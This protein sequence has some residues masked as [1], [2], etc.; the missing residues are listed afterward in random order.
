[1]TST[2]GA[3]WRSPRWSPAAASSR[4]PR[5]AARCCSPASTSIPTRRIHEAVILPYARIGRHVRLNKVVVDSE[6]IIPDGL[7][8]GE[9]PELDAKRFRRTEDGVTPDHRADDRSAQELTLRDGAAEGPLGRL[10]SL[11]ARQD[12]RPRRCRGRAA[13]RAEARGRRDAHASAS[14]SAGQG[15]ARESHRSRSISPICSAGPARVLAAPLAGLDLF[16]LDAPHLFDRAGNP[17][18]GADG[19]DWP[20][21]AD[22]LRRARR[23]SARTS[24]SA[25]SR[26][27]SPMSSMRMTGRPRS[28]RPICISPAGRGPARW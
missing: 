7:V 11:S 12:R 24:A 9:D 13:E 23:A 6:V 28:R 8:V 5:S 17:Y 1:M 22:P 3:A 16:A 25:R 14:L 15:E 4:A 21:N 26:P 27:S 20:D 19:V 18:L 2:A 10:G